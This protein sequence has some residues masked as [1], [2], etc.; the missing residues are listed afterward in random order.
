VKHRD[1][2]SRVTLRGVTDAQSRLHNFPIPGRVNHPLLW[3]HQGKRKPAF[4]AS[5]RC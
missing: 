2:V 3:D 4:D 1:K 5:S